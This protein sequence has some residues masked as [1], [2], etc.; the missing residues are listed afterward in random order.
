MSSKRVAVFF[1]SAMAIFPPAGFAQDQFV[2]ESAR[3]IPVACDVDVV[4]VGGSSA[5]VAAAVKAAEHGASVFLL[6]SRPYLG[7]DICGPFRYWLDPAEVPETTLGKEIFASGSAVP[8]VTYVS[9]PFTYSASVTPTNENHGDDGSVLCDNQYLSAATQSVQYDQNVT[10]VAELK[11]EQDV[12]D[13]HVLVYQRPRDF[14]V[15][16]VLVSVSSDGK[17]WSH[18]VSIVRSFMVVFR[19]AKDRKNAT[20]AERKATLISRTMLTAM[21]L[22]SDKGRFEDAAIPISASVDRE[23]RYVI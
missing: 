16:E 7:E 12:N 10:I 11:K 22:E 3:E 20:F 4:V 23:G 9:A 2:V 19:S 15:G 1:L 6:S 13:V 8:Q 14:G 5:G 21:N 18:P 17:N